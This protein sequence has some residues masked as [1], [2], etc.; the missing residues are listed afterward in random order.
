MGSF[1]KID[2]SLTVM[3]IDTSHL[4]CMHM[5]PPSYRELVQPLVVN[6]NYGC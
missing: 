2:R 6:K 5:V 1:P 3:T 4:A